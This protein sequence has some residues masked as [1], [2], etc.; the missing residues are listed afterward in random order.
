M[1]LTFKARSCPIMTAVRFYFPLLLLAFALP[2]S[3]SSQQHYQP[4]KDTLMPN[5]LATEQAAVM[6]PAKAA[7]PFVLPLA[8]QLQDTSLQ[9]QPRKLKEQ[10]FTRPKVS[11]KTS[12]RKA[13]RAK[14]S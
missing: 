2:L 10:E 4:L 14:I 6:E 9:K 3:S 1:Q 5:H 7:A 12:M 11:K 13:R 8:T